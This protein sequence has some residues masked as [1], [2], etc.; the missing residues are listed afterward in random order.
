MGMKMCS[1][2]IDREAIESLLLE[3]QRLRSTLRAM[4]EE[5]GANFPAGERAAVDAAREILRATKGD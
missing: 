5:F 4:Y 3:N 2:I 1:E